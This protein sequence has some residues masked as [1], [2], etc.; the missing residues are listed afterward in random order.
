[1]FWGGYPALAYKIF[2]N[3]H[4]QHA[5]S[6]WW[7]VNCGRWASDYAITGLV[8]ITSYRLQFSNNRRGWERREICQLQNRQCQQVITR[9]M[10]FLPVTINS[11]FGPIGFLITTLFRNLLNVCTQ[12]FHVETNWHRM[13]LFSVKG[14]KQ[15]VSGSLCSI[16][17]LCMSKSNPS[18]YAGITNL[19]WSCFAG[20]GT[21][22]PNF[23]TDR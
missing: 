22:T 1:V 13:A 8:P 14:K 23:C 3:I 15:R 11:G 21:K 9:M 19:S 16:W 12:Y 5:L 17:P 10:L 4:L 7:I 2:R 18:K 6:G 20:A